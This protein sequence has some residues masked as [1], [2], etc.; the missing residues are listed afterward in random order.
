MNDWP[1]ARSPFTLFDEV[2]EASE[3][4]VLSYT[5]NLDFFERFSLAH[6]RALGA[7]V[8]VIA[9]AEMVS[10]DPLVVRHAGTAYLDAR[11]IC[12]GAFHPK[13]LVIVGR[14]E[15]RVAIGSGNLTMAGWHGNAEISTVL[16]AD[17]DSGGPETIHQVADFLDALVDSPVKLTPGA[18]PALERAAGFL[19][20]LPT[21]GPGPRLVHNL[22][23]SIA[24]QLPSGPVEEFVC[25]APF[26]DRSLAA[27]RELIGQLQPR[28]LSILVQPETSVDGPALESLAEEFNARINWVKD[29]R[30]HHGKLVEW[31]ADG[32]RSALTGSPNLS[33]SALSATVE[34]GNCELGLISQVPSSLAPAAGSP[35]Q[36]WVSELS[37]ERDRSDEAHGFLLLGAVNT[38]TGVRLLLN[39]PLPLGGIVQGY[40]RVGDGWSKIASIAAGQETY[41]LDAGLAQPGRAL[42]IVLDDSRSSNQ[43]FV[44]DLDR[45]RRPQASAVGRVRKSPSDVAADGLGDLLLADLDQLREHLL[46]VGALVV[47]RPAGGEH[48][49]GGPD[50][51][52]NEELPKAR[53]A[54]GQTLEDFVNACDPVLG[55]EMTEFG[56]VLPALPGVG[57]SIEE[58]EKLELDTDVD[59]PSKE[60]EI[61]EE[62]PPRLTGAIKSLSSDDRDRYRRFIERLVVRSSGYP[63][64]LRTLA[65]RTIFHGMAAGLW[66]EEEWPDL[67]AHAMTALVVEGDKP[68]DEERKAAASMAAIA[69]A[70][71]RTQVARISVQDEANLRFKGAAQAVAPLLAFVDPERVEL[72]APDLPEPLTGPAGVEAARR[73]INEVLNPLKPVAQAVR[74]LGDEYDT[75]AEVVSDEAFRLLDALPTYFEPQIFRGLGLAHSDGPIVAYG[76]TEGGAQVVAVWDAPRLVVEQRKD[77]RCWGRTYAL[78]GQLTPMNYT[79]L[80]DRPPTESRWMKESERANQASRLLER[81]T[82]TAHPEPSEVDEA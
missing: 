72:V 50:A 37:I 52:G 56:L 1:E 48:G 76:H 17:S 58:D 78:P 15:A 36:T 2:E 66:S 5:A 43:V 14:E 4:L 57:M 44:A 19:R 3:V 32:Q 25:C 18:S 22:S 81:A 45:V 68:T 69:L 61:E 35:P 13:L 79:G 16:R 46:R 73:V 75:P 65:L 30:Y 31:V 67:L 55:R 20:G 41:E 74:L 23:E 64:L 27:L 62:S 34:G 53:P 9:D 51:D 26:Y 54:P 80:E 21:D 7:L 60:S 6:A 29:R 70:L 49:E 8:T 38:P 33:T 24:K 39:R 10:A 11:A 63:L 28:E 59:D 71:E 47:P 40:D 12:E 77:G 42:R 82:G